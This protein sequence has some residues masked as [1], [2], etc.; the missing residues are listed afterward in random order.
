MA[1]LVGNRNVERLGSKVLLVVS[2]GNVSQK[3]LSQVLAS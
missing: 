3:L 1:A 2:G